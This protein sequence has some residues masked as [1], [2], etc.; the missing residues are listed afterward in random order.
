MIMAKLF[1]VI[2]ASGV[3]KDSLI[4]YCRENLPDTA[5]VLF[6]HRY[7]TRPAHAGG[8]NHVAL[9]EQEFLQRRQQGC[10]TMNW[11]SHNTHYGIGSEIDT[12]L[13]KGFNVVVNGSREYLQAAA[14]KYTN[15]API[16]ITADPDLLADRLFARGRETFQQVSHRISHAIKLADA[17][18]HPRLHKIENNGEIEEAGDQLLKVI[19]GREQD[20]CA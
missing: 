15:L 18:H 5:P 14:E 6:A 3:G 20:Q 16:L 11:F 1:Y 8:E 7:I 4:D 9:T 10:F 13:A 2:G 19:L 17:V 12:W